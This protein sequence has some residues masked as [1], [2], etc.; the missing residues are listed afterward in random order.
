MDRQ[1]IDLKDLYSELKDQPS[2]N[3]KDLGTWY[4]NNL[5]KQT[6]IRKTK[7]GFKILVITLSGLLFMFSFFPNLTDFWLRIIQF[8]S[9]SLMVSIWIFLKH[10]S[11]NPDKNLTILKLIQKSNNN[12]KKD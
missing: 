12:S 10:E 11:I 3:D 7:S 2:V 4:D 1:T 5:K 8:V 6:E 9:F